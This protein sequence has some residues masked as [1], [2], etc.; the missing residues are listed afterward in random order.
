MK[1]IEI[2]KITLNV[3]AGKDPKKLEKGILLLKHLTGI[4][5]VKTIT[6]K[7]I[8]TWGL[9]PGLPIGCKITI[10]DKDVIK[11]LLPRFLKAKNN[12]LQET[13]FDENGNL[14]FGIHEYIDIPGVQYTPDVGIMGFQI[15]IT[16]KRPG[17]RVKARKVQ[18]RKIKKSH[19]ISRQEAMEFMKNSFNVSTNAE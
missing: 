16:L 15:T 7:R 5:P 11:N 1:R 19:R 14:A 12:S 3:G 8:P 4:N 13:Q 18:K 6:Q 2:E 17:F 9:R 10:R